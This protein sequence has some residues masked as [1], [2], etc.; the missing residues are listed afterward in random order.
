LR[1]RNPEES[2]IAVLDKVV[3]RKRRDEFTRARDAV[4]GSHFRDV[5]L[6]A[7]LWLLDGA[8]SQRKGD[9]ADRRS[10]TIAAVA[11]NILDR[12]S[13]KII[14]KT[15]RLQKLDAQRRHKLRIAVKK[16][17]YGCEF[18]ET[19]FEHPKARKQY[20][21][22]LKERQD[23]L[24]KLNDI[25]VHRRR[26]RRV[27]NPRRRTPQQ[28]QEAYAMG[29]LTGQEQGKRRKLVAR[30]IRSGRKIA[31]ARPFW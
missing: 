13:R 6:T 8:W 15:T 26:G 31:D 22:T 2:E 20:E 14:K 25:E 21:R 16:F 5:V 4:A 30:A 10:K 27:A 12:R 18:F 11:A 9:S 3:Q 24:G 23:C 29:L 1:E 28:S 7:A 19:L 17:R